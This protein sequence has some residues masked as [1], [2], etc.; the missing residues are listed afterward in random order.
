MEAEF[1]KS[2]IEKYNTKCIDSKIS[3]NFCYNELMYKF[4]KYLNQRNKIEL[5]K[6]LN[7]KDL[8]KVKVI[9]NKANVNSKQE[10]L[11][12]AQSDFKKTQKDL[13]D[14]LDK[15][16]DPYFFILQPFYKFGSGINYTPITYKKDNCSGIN[17]IDIACD[18]ANYKIKTRI[19]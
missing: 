2:E 9:L 12:S 15:T 5:I 1:F 11:I 4:E 17:N 19:N 6:R 14:F 16:K 3:V 7:F 18:Y 8:F 13:F 10:E